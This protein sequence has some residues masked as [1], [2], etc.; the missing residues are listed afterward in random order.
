VPGTD[1]YHRRTAEAFKKALDLAGDEP[2]LPTW[3]WRDV[4]ARS[5]E[6]LAAVE[7]DTKIKRELLDDAVRELEAASD[8]PQLKGDGQTAKRNEIT[9]RLRQLREQ[10]KNLR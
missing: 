2:D 9:Q 8:S 5:L 6:A 10:A 4:R 7:K 1:G 3:A